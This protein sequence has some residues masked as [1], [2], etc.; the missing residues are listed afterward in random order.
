MSDHGVL[1]EHSPV[2]GLEQPVAPVLEVVNL[3]VEFRTPG[4]TVRAVDR[5]S[6]SLAE[7]QRMVI[8]GESGSGKT[9]SAEAV[10]GILPEPPARVT[11][12]AINFRG[13]N[14]LDMSASRRRKLRGSSIAMVFQ[15]ALT[16]LNPAF[17]V[18][19]QIAEL[20]Q[21]H[22]GMSRA[23]AMRQA[24]EMLDRVRIPS[25]KSRTR[26]YPHQF[27]GGMRQRVMIAMALA[28][29]PAVLIADE[30]TTALD[31]TVQA[32]ILELL[33]EVTS[34]SRTAL[35]LI[36]HDLGVAAEI[37]DR[38]AVMY[39]GRLAE[40]GSPSEIFHQPLHP[41][42]MGLLASV[43]RIDDK[44]DRLLAIGGTPPNL[45]HVPSGCAFHPRCEHAID[46]CRSDQP[47]FVLFEGEHGS[48][49]HLSREFLS[50]R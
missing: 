34:E 5:L 4:G 19:D 35:M 29:D 40:R 10:M 3:T 14:L 16:A 37:A 13:E 20:Y 17:T 45:A 44:K 50:D 2:T 33:R 9:V 21:V 41:Y 11:A 23:A 49:C 43:P 46:R 48:A 25:A 12:D 32:Q 27:S 47:A 36:T 38:I 15:D 28:L 6:Y 8:L 24:T 7:G 22:R 1:S 30:P 39:S 42:T 26:D 31:V 18:G